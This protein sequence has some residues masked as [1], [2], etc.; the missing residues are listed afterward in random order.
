[1]KRILHIVMLCSFFI[2]ILVLSGCDDKPETPEEQHAKNFETFLTSEILKPKDLSIPTLSQ[3][4]MDSFGVYKDHY[5]V[6]SQFHDRLDHVF[7]ENSPYILQSLKSMDSLPNIQKNWLETRNVLALLKQKLQPEIEQAY[8]E[9]LKQKG[10]LKQPEAVQKLFNEAFDRCVEQPAAEALKL[11]PLFEKALSSA[12]QMGMFL[13][14]NQN[15]FKFS[16]LIIQ[17]SNEAF[18]GEL[19]ILMKNYA[20]QEAALNKQ[21]L[22]FKKTLSKE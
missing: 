22:L 2:G 5:K 15:S 6:I 17:T 4:Q 3:E 14:D 13:E 8:Q 18:Q 1:M 19:D 16:G 21:L 9:A 7:S 11:F 10:S 12:V 20:A